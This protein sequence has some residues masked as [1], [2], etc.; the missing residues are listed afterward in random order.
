MKKKYRITL[1]ALL[2]LGI[3]LLLYS[4][5]QQNTEDSD[6]I[7][8]IDQT[9]IENG[10]E[11]LISQKDDLGF[12]ESI[13]QTHIE[14][15]T[16]DLISQR[17]EDFTMN[18][19]KDVDKVEVNHHDS[20][21][22]VSTSLSIVTGSK[23][24]KEA[25]YEE[26]ANHALQITRFFP[27]VNY[28]SYVVWGTR[29]QEEIIILTLDQDDIDKLEANFSI[30]KGKKENNIET[31]FIDVF[32]TA[33]EMNVALKWE[34]NFDESIKL[35]E[36]ESKIEEKLIVDRIVA[37]SKRYFRYMETAQAVFESGNISVSIS[38]EPEVGSF[39]VKEDIYE[40][41]INHALRV[42]RFFPEVNFLMY[43]VMWKDNEAITLTIEKEDIKWLGHN[44]FN[45]ITRRNSGF[46]TSFVDCFTTVEE[47]AEARR[48]RSVAKPGGDL[49]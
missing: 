3:S 30:N 1:S 49:P 15:S 12:V 27:E 11:D 33:T 31:R 43:V 24:I 39:P 9:H 14:N 36:V 26:I 4:F 41:I 46:R 48:W 29:P 10:T 37:F 6:L 44:W 13:S 42:I 20:D 32:S 40:D 25:I 5:I 8:S 2:L 16:N 17:I 45:N 18:F 23:P 19:L 38:F 22:S 34:S 28:F 21:I 7:E 47:S 35:S